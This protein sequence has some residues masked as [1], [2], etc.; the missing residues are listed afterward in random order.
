M[1]KKDWTTSSDFNNYS[2]LNSE[3]SI[4]ITSL[5]SFYYEGDHVKEGHGRSKQ[6]T[7]HEPCPSKAR[8]VKHVLGCIMKQFFQGFPNKEENIIREF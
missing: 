2:I 6:Q 5:H 4:L 8:G 7:P 1:L 3:P